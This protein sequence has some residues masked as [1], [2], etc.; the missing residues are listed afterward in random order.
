MICLYFNINTLHFKEYTNN[1]KYATFL[2]K[3]FSNSLISHVKLTIDRTQQCTF[4]F[5]P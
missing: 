1:T 2:L 4:I 3:I 5:T